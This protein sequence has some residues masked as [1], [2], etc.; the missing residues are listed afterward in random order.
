[1]YAMTAPTPTDDPSMPTLH[2]EH[3]ITD[4]ATWMSAFDRFADARR[5]ASVRSERIRQPVGDPHGIVIDLEFDTV[6][7]AERFLGFLEERVWAIPE[8]APALDSAPR[9]VV[10]VDVAEGPTT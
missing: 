7:D 9:T 10:L 1:M 4:L 8:N 2:I 6:E 5:Q 3:G